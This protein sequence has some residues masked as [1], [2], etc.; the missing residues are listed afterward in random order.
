MLARGS[1]P[2]WRQQRGRIPSPIASARNR[3]WCGKRWTRPGPH[4]QRYSPE[5]IL[6]QII[7]YCSAFLPWRPC[8]Y[9][10]PS[11]SIIICVVPIAWAIVRR[12]PMKC[13]CMPGSTKD[14]L[15]AIWG[16]RLRLLPRSSKNWDASGDQCWTPDCE[17]VFTAVGGSAA[18]WVPNSTYKG[19]RIT[20]EITIKFFKM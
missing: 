6:Q 12:R 10:C 5:R 1:H 15:E 4:Y 2:I 20:L 3:R 14:A 7:F 16:S 18:S 8:S 11:S 17:N 13:V 9:A 19:P